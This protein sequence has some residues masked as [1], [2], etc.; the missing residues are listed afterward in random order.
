MK[1]KTN[2]REGSTAEKSKLVI[3]FYGEIGCQG[4][5]Y[6]GYMYLFYVSLLSLSLMRHVVYVFTK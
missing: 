6:F 1:Q 4:K 2:D 5:I 3:Y